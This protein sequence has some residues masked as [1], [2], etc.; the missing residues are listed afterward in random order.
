[1]GQVATQDSKPFVIFEELSA[2]VQDRHVQFIGAMWEAVMDS[3][4]TKQQTPAARAFNI[5]EAIDILKGFSTEELRGAWAQERSDQ[6]EEH[7][8]MKVAVIPEMLA[9]RITNQRRMKMHAVKSKEPE[10]KKEPRITG[11]RSNEILRE[12]GMGHL[13]SVGNIAKNMRP[14][15]MQSHNQTQ[16]QQHEANKEF[17]KAT[18]A[19]QKAAYN[20]GEV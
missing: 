14:K 5:Q 10:P 2:E 13:P 18:T 1:M 9:R 17:L 3:T 12:Y 8:R 7:G 19:Q 16:Q 15:P 6:V 4:Y 20:A 11:E